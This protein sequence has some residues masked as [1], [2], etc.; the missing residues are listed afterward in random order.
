V[1]V[2]IFKTSSDGTRVIYSY[3]DSYVIGSRFE[4][5]KKLYSFSALANRTAARQTVT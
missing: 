2:G 3:R 4:H 5:G 1:A